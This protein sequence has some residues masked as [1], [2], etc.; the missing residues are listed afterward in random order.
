M[1]ISHIS[2]LTYLNLNLIKLQFKIIIINVKLISSYNKR[3]R[4]KFHEI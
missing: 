4:R 2:L 3:R 1:D